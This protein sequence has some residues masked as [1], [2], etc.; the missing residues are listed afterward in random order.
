MAK[1]RK[2]PIKTVQIKNPSEQWKTQ[3]GKLPSSDID[4]PV[5]QFSLLD[6]E[7]PWGWRDVKANQWQQI[8][9]KLGHF[10]TRTWADIKSDGNNHTVL[11]QKNPNSEVLK[12]LTEIHL[13]DIEELFSLRLSGKERLWG[14]LDNHIFK[15]LWWDPNHEVWPSTKKHT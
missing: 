15:I 1:K 11:I 7:G 2:S 5:W 6:W 14:I 4:K 8:L 13:D 3:L 12:R 9:Q 10:E